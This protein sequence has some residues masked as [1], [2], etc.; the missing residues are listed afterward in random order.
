VARRDRNLVA[1]IERD[2]LDGSVPLAS[3]LRRCVV[4]GGKSGSEELRDWATRELQG[5][6]GEDNLPAYRIVAAPLRVDGIV[7]R[8]KVSRQAFPPASLPDFA[9]E[10][11]QDEVELRDGIGTIEGFLDLA[12][13]K[14]SPP[15][16]SDLVLYMNHES[17]IPGQHIESLYWQVSHAAIRGVL[18]RIRTSLT[19]LVAELRANMTANE[20]VPSTEA[21]DQAVQVVVTGKRSKVT[22]T[23][24]QA[25]DN[26]T[27]SL[28]MEDPRRDESKFWT[29]SR[30]IGAF[31]V[32][33]ASIAGAV[34]AVLQ[35]V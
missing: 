14:L 29:R 28:R 33:L 3:A 35:V 13:I 6:H 4:L 10:H 8:A 31:A 24:A 11:I 22:V 5:Y 18:D 32:G 1:Q 17:G 21:A 23:T 27:A 34:A 15:R 25:S 19:Q 7:G 9:R 30:R 20:D 2:A 16:A 26:G 12:E